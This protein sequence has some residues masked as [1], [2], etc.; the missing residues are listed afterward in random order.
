[1]FNYLEREAP[2]GE[3][4][5]IRIYY[6]DEANATAGWQ[7]LATTLNTDFNLASAQVR[8]P[9]VY[10]LLTSV[11]I[12]LAQGWNLIAYPVHATRPVSEALRSIDAAYT[13]IYGY[14][15]GNPTAPYA[16][17]CH[18]DCDVPVYK[19]HP[20]LEV[21][22]FGRGYWLYVDRPVTLYLKGEQ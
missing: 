1:M 5:G 12:P 19:G 2:A 4:A 18:R 11:E 6:L 16:V 17:Y 21:L 3:E 8:G 14:D 22:T 9:G 13:V 10:A 15:P 7:P 20:P